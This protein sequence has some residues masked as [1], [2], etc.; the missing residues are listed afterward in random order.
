MSYFPVRVFIFRVRF[1]LSRCRDD[2]LDATET[3]VAGEE[4]QAWAREEEQQQASD[5]ERREGKR[6]LR[7]CRRFFSFARVALSFLSL[8]PLSATD[9][10]GRYVSISLRE[11]AVSQRHSNIAAPQGE[12]KRERRQAPTDADVVDLHFLSSL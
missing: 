5:E 1:H 2:A 11:R 12:I 6:M 8:A 10:R 3:S 4:K 9:E 7:R